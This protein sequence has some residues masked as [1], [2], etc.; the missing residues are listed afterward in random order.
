MWAPVFSLAWAPT[1]PEGGEVGVSRRA[2]VL[3]PVPVVGHSLRGPP[4][5]APAS[6]AEFLESARDI[7][8]RRGG[9]A[10]TRKKR[11]TSR[12]IWCQAMGERG[13]SEQTT[14]ATR[15]LKAMAAATSWLSA[16]DSECRREII[17]LRRRCCPQWLTAIAAE[18]S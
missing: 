10:A 7:G 12:R 8:Q 6:R 11:E 16:T 3:G 5:R 9:V 1:E 17:S 15:L 4:I 18:R 2:T 13:V 14:A